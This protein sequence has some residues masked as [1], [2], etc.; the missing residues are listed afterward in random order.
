MRLSYLV[1]YRALAF[2]RFGGLPFAVAVV[3]CHASQANFNWQK[4]TSRSS[5]M[6]VL[7]SVKWAFCAEGHM[8]RQPC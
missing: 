7:A 1:L 2:K 8:S 5:I 4:E 6:L 3:V